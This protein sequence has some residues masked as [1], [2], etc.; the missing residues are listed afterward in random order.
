M[1][2]IKLDLDPQGP[3]TYDREV[4]IPTPS[5]KPLKVMFTFKHRTREEMAELRE[6][7][8]AKARENYVQATAEV[9]QEKVR[10]EADEKAGRTYMPPEPKL[11]EGVPEAIATDVAATMDIATDWNIDSEFNATNLSKF[12]S[13][14]TA[15][16][17]AIGDDYFVSMTEGRL[18]N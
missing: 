7:Y 1:A 11:V 10:R 12:F 2:K 4:A 3:I 17:K 14:Y 15:A 9:E 5:G 8:I 16:P 6:R 18:G 13:L